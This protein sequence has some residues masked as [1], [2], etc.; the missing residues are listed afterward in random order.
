[1]DFPVRFHA[2]RWR[3]L[4]L[5]IG[6]MFACAA[7]TGLC[8][9]GFG[10][11]DQLDSFSLTMKGVWFGK[12]ISSHYYY[13]GPDCF[14]MDIYM[15]D[16][17]VADVCVGADCWTIVDGEVGDL[18][19]LGRNQLLQG[20]ADMT[21]DIGAISTYYGARVE[22]SGKSIIDGVPVTVWCIREMSRLDAEIQDLV[23]GALYVETSTGLPKR[24]E[25]DYTAMDGTRRVFT[26][27][28]VDGFSFVRK[29][30]LFKG[31]ER[32]ILITVEETIVN[33]PIDVA[34]FERP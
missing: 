4:F 12:D 16:R 31:E 32:I 13:K 33:G 28:L 15:A 34:L 27:G 8:D 11:P 7:F 24:L 20:F 21:G 3:N 23:R 1:M 5:S 18:D 29:L 2:Q 14:R 22:A 6:L 10:S 30:E 19:E 17:D 26:Y 9:C 25:F